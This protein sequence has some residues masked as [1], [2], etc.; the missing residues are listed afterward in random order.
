MLKYI[1]KEKYDIDWDEA[2]LR[3]VWFSGEAQYGDC[4]VR[5]SYLSSQE[6]LNLKSGTEAEFKRGEGG[7]TDYWGPIK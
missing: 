7:S 5:T 3:R 4:A 2:H 6:I 1:N